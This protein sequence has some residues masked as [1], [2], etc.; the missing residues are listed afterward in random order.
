MAAFVPPSWKVRDALP[1]EISTSLGRRVLPGDPTD[2]RRP[3]PG[4]AVAPPGASSV[5]MR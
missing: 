1:A 5:R 3:Q 2:L 4:L